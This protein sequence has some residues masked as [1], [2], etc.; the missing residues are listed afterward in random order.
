MK[1]LS[2]N[3]VAEN[4]N[5][6][7][8]IM[9]NISSEAYRHGFESMVCYG[10]NCAVLPSYL[11]GYK[12]NSNLD[13]YAHA[14]LSRIGDSEG[15]HS[16]RATMRLINH[17]CTYAPDI[18]HLHNIHGHYLN[19]PLLFDFLKRCNIPIVWTM[20]DC[21]AYTGHCVYYSHDECNAWRYDCK[22]CKQQNKYPKSYLLSK[23][24]RNFKLKKE[25]F[26]AVP[27]LH[28]VAV[29]DWLKNEIEESFLSDYP[30]HRIYNGVDTDVF[31]RVPT[32]QIDSREVKIILGVASQW[33][34]RKGLDDFYA[35][36]SLLPNDYKI[37]IVGYVPKTLIRN[38]DNIIFLGKLSKNELVE[39]YLKA[40]IYVNASK[41]E[42]FGMT[43]IEALSCETP[44]I[45]N[46]STALPEII[47]PYRSRYAQ[48]V[49]TSRTEHLLNAVIQAT[50]DEVPVSARKKLRQ[51]TI[52]SFSSTRMNQEYMKL[53][54]SITDR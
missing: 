8:D 51:K 18:I 7:A 28:I 17:I 40:S 22:R 3:T 16:G 29:S 30:I 37:H 15:L 9:L 11:V 41:E 6:P 38:T 1:L 2:I 4:S 26:T 10:R 49:D 25:Y 42:T 52:D 19:Y 34:R 33:D 46:S 47:N 45:V 44:V 13:V 36:S 14:L 23:S 5:A 24:K 32:Y 31:K 39:Q 35:L 50:T 20:H 54:K 21:W 43:T 27:N 53:F 12:I 48:I